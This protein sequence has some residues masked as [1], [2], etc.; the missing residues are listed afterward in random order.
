MIK[1]IVFVQVI[2]LSFCLSTFA[3]EAANISIPEPELLRQKEFNTPINSVA[4]S[5]DGTRIAIT[6]NPVEQDVEDDRYPFGKKKL[7]W[8]GGSK[9]YY[10]DN[11][12]NILWEYEYKEEEPKKRCYPGKPF[13]YEGVRLTNVVMS[14]DG[15]YIACVIEDLY[16]YEQPY[17]G[18][19]IELRQD[20]TA[21][22][23]LFF[24]SAG[25][26]LWSFDALG[27]PQ[28]STDGNYIFIIPFTYEYVS[29]LIGDF[30]FLDKN[31]KKLWQTTGL[32]WKPKMTKDAFRIIIGDTLYDK[33]GNILWK[34]SDGFFTDITPDGSLGIVI[35]PRSVDD[36]LP[37]YREI[38]YVDL[39]QKKTLWQ[40]VE[41]EKSPVPEN[42]RKKFLPDISFKIPKG[43]ENKF[44]PRGD[45]K[46]VYNKQLSLVVTW[47]GE[48]Y[49]LVGLEKNLYLYEIKQDEK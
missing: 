31:G 35:I 3:Q 21:F 24:N 38:L 41:G 15:E 14:D 22:R 37:P 33:N 10:L 32:S 1:K 39:N 49:V 4:I 7:S 8:L 12:G 29:Y 40:E 45:W 17:Y 30:Y 23:T 28:I 25:K 42:L 47:A 6:V 34:L 13:S 20:R 48:R 46:K 19:G 16:S 18:K 11:K 9:L 44:P 26:L 5:S 2:F 36:F 43:L 27:K